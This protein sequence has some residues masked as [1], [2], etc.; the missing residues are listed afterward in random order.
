MDAVA[1]LG[2][3]VGRE[4]A[5][6]KDLGH[7]EGG[8]LI[9]TFLNCEIEVTPERSK[10]ADDTVRQHD[11][12]GMAAGPRFQPH[13]NRPH[14]KMHGLALTKGPL[15]EGKIIITI[16]DSILEAAVCERSVFKT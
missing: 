16:V 12:E 3:L 5:G 7:A 15:D 2:K 13:V 8:K 4:F 6:K 9:E 1:R 10:R 11:D 14:L